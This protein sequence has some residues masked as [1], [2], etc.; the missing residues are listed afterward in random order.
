MITF[1]SNPGAPNVLGK[2]PG[3]HPSVLEFL[4]QY[5][6]ALLGSDFYEAS[7]HG[8]STPY[9]IHAIESEIRLF[10]RRTRDTCGPIAT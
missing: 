9:P 6:A 7:N 8:Y 4:Y 5:D 2:K 3:L 10:M 1:K